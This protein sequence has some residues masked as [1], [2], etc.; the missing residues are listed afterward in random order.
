MICTIVKTELVLRQSFRRKVDKQILGTGP[1]LYPP[2]LCCA[3]TAYLRRLLRTC[4]SRSTLCGAIKPLE[5]MKHNILGTK[6]HIRDQPAARGRSRSTLRAQNIRRSGK[7][8]LEKINVSRGIRKSV[9]HFVK[10]IQS[11]EDNQKIPVNH[12]LKQN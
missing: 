5:P 8:L 4:S 9:K 6:P 12:V 2:R 11:F 10:Q 7:S 3:R 1:G